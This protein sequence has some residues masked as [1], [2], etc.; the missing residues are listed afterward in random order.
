CLPLSYR[1]KLSWPAAWCSSFR[2]DLLLLMRKIFTVLALLTGLLVARPGRAQELKA[3]V[4]VSLQNV[5]VTD[6][7]L[8]ARMQS[9][10]RRILEE[11]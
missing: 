1:L 5:T 11:T 4:E 2:P 6:G 3:T 8:V 7:T 9:E 10:I